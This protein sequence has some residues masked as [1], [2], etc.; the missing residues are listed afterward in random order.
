M[1]PWAA[2]A[3]LPGMQADLRQGPKGPVSLTLGVCGDR[4]AQPGR[5]AIATTLDYRLK[6]AGATVI[7]E[8]YHPGD[9]LRAD[10][11]LVRGVDG[12]TG[13]GLGRL[14]ADST[15]WRRR[16]GFRAAHARLFPGQAIPGIQPFEDGSAFDPQAAAS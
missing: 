7:R 15:A 1:Q 16:E 3:R 8:P 11:R 9:L 4:I 5:C 10:L 13:R 2:S 6:A 12:S 14:L